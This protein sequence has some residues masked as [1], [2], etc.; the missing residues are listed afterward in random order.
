ML[1]LKQG[2]ALVAVGSLAFVAGRM[3]PV[4]DAVLAAQPAKDSKVIQPGKNKAPPTA[5]QPG[6]GAMPTPGAE[7]KLLAPLIGDF[8][9][10]AK[11]WME[12]GTEPMEVKGAIHREWDMDG[13]FVIER[14]TGDGGFKGM[15]IIGYNTVEKRYESAWIENMASY[16]ATSNGNYDAKTKMLT[17]TGDMIHPMTQK[18]VKTRSTIDLSK[19]EKEV[20]TTYTTGPDGKEYKSF[21]GTFARVKK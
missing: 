14:V 4:G 16:I 19:S 2:V 6:E 12:A 11:M 21:E 9:G 1:Q 18:R 7:H 17:F 15:G 3:L 8:E 13:W 20:M 10:T 5:A